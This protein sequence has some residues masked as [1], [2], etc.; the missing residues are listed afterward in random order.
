[1]LATL[2]EVIPYLQEEERVYFESIIRNM[3]ETLFKIQD[4]S[5]LWHTLINMK[6][7]YLETSGSALLGYGINKAISLGI[8]SE[9][10]KD[11][12]NRLFSG[13][14]LRISKEGDVLGVSEGTGPGDYIYYATR[15]T[16]IFPHGQGSVLLFLGGLK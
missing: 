5:G 15:S 4:K 8:I 11:T 1:M 2:V 10:Y 7:T 12:V 3:V 13:I 14:K 6:G 16:G 9:I